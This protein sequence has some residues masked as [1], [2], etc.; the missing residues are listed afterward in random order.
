MWPRHFINQAKS[1]FLWQEE[2]EKKSKCPAEMPSCLDQSL[3][4]ELFL[5]IQ[6]LLRRSPEERCVV[7]ARYMRVIYIYEY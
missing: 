7:V 5:C 2:G 3:T 6:P 4:D 1:E